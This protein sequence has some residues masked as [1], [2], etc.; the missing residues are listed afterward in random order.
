MK[1]ADAELTTTSRKVKISFSF[2]SIFPIT[3]S[4]LRVWNRLGWQKRPPKSIRSAWVRPVPNIGPRF[5]KH[6]SYSTMCCGHSHSDMSY[7]W[8]Q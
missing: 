6:A 8:E 5:G 3:R 4:S 1:C 7:V 2:T